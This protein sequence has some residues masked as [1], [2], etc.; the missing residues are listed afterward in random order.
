MGIM[1]SY[2]QRSNRTK[3]KMIKKGHIRFIRYG[4]GTQYL[5]KIGPIGD[6]Q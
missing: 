3:S 2:Q 1:K 6:N 4:P 5:L